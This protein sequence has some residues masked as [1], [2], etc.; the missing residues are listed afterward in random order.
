MISKTVS[1]KTTD[2]KIHASIEDARW[3]E[4]VCHLN[5]AET[6][7][8]DRT[9]AEGLALI[10]IKDCERFVDLL[11]LK[12]SSK[13][14][15]RKINGATKKRTAKPDVANAKPQQ[16]PSQIAVKEMVEKHNAKTQQLLAE[17]GAVK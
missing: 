2:G 12:A 7:N 16:F 3:H 5:N 6:Y 9:A 8:M 1:F 14:S 11:T 15:A 4:I 17:V 13:P 10:L